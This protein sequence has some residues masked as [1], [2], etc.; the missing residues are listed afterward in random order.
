MDLL[1]KVPGNGC[2]SFFCL[3]AVDP[4][5]FFPLNITYGTREVYDRVPQGISSEVNLAPGPDGQANG[6]YE[7]KGTS[8]SYIEFS[9]SAEGVLDVRYSITMLC[10]VY[11]DGQ[12]GPLFNY[13]TN[14]DWGVHLW[15]IEGKLFV[16]FTKRNYSFTDAL[17]NGNLADG[18]RCVGA[19]Y[20]NVTGEAKLWMDG[21]FVQTLNI[22]VGLE[23]ATQDSVRMGVKT[24]DGRYFKGK[25]TQMRVYDVALPGELIQEILGKTILFKELIYNK[26]RMLLATS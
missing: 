20:N 24:G 8:N 19:S 13:K 17:L 26:K 14:G 4:V 1:P 11:Y 25:I 23:L 15:A 18:W 5:A 12:D 16:R 2:L 3:L 22:G 9:N 7:F 21:V 10:W 6:S